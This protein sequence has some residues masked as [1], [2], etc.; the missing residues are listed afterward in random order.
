MKNKDSDAIATI[1]HFTQHLQ[2]A[3]VVNSTRKAFY[4]EKTQGAA[5]WVCRLLILSEKLFLPLARYFD[6][7]A[8]PFNGQGVAIIADDFV[9][10]TDIKPVDTPPLFTGRATKSERSLLLAQLKKFQR[11][12]RC[13]LASRDYAKIAELT[14]KQ[15]HDVSV[16]EG[17]C[18]A[19]FAMTIHLLESLGFAALHAVTYLK[20]SP[21]CAVLCR[22]F[23]GIQIALVN[24]GMLFD[25][26]AQNCHAQGAGI[27]VNDVPHIPFL[28]EYAAKNQ[29]S[30]MATPPVRCAVPLPVCVTGT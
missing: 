30:I 23:V 21:Q 25:R 19:H 16:F 2:D 12:A 14:A 3:I 7:Q 13:A 15:L 10:M 24:S 17:Q 18:S 26:L 4:M 8:L 1:G 28:S 5:I 6:R 27:I 20:E 29:H 9:P 11:H 22:R